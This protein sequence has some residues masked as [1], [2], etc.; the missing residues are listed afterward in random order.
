MQHLEDAS[1]Y[2]K[3]N[4]KINMKILKNLNKLLNKYC[5]SFTEPEQKFLTEKF[6]KISNFC[7]LRKIHQSKIIET[8]IHSQN[9]EVAEVGEPSDLKVTPIVWG[10]GA[11][12]QLEDLDILHIHF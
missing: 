11:M 7:G 1:T 8:T 2:Q 5:K 3:L 10:G 6:V 4:F 12:F 9:T